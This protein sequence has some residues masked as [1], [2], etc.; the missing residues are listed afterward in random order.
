MRQCAKPDARAGHE[1]YQAKLVKLHTTACAPTVNSATR[2]L[3]FGVEIKQ[4][5]GTGGPFLHSD[6][7]VPCG[8]DVQWC[9]TMH[10]PFTHNGTLVSRG[11]EP[12]PSA[13]YGQVNHSASK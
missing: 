10:V 3:A 5:V 8:S 4:A 2:A 7:T 13:T 11:N 9:T 12:E 1:K 6:L